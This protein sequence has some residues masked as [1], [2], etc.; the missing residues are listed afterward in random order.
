MPGARQNFLVE[1]Y[2]GYSF[3]RFT[4]AGSSTNLN[5]GMGS[6]GYNLKP[7]LQIVGDSSYNFVTIGGTKNADCAPYIWQGV[8][9]G[10]YCGAETRSTAAPLILSPFSA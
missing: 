10:G 4:S 1:L 5:G 2:S 9:I 6:F 3:A 8:G 7:W